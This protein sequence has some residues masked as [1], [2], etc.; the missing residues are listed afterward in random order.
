MGPQGVSWEEAQPQRQCGSGLSPSLPGL[1]SLASWLDSPEP[2]SPGLWMRSPAAR[3]LGSLREA[4]VLQ[5]TV[6]GNHRGLDLPQGP[7]GESTGEGDMGSTQVGRRGPSHR[8]SP[9]PQ[10]LLCVSVSASLSQAES[11]ETLSDSLDE[12]VC[13]ACCVLVPLWVLGICG[14]D[15]PPFSESHSSGSDFFV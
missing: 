10:L 12:H 6:L 1:V 7:A 15:R 11:S 9:P 4:L 2:R 14:P 3:A 8:L 5:G 13:S